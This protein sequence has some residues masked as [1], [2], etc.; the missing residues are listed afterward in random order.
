MLLIHI[1]FSPSTQFPSPPSQ[2]QFGQQ[3]LSS[4][5]PSNFGDQFQTTQWPSNFGQFL[6]SSSSPSPPSSSSAQQWPFSSQQQFGQNMP[7]QS[8]PSQPSIN[9]GQSSANSGQNQRRPQAVDPASLRPI[10]QSIGQMPTSTA[11]C[12]R[13]K[14]WNGG[15]NWWTEFGRRADFVGSI[16][17]LFVVDLL[18][19]TLTL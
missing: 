12:N 3:S 6:S 16:L 9:V 18:L 15:G 2:Q 4:Q 11:Q 5:W 7:P 14:R 19:L 10:F 8:F 1:Y 13:R 17:L